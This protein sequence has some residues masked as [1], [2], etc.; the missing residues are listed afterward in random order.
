MVYTCVILDMERGLQSL[1]KPEDP[2]GKS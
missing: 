2:F 1:V